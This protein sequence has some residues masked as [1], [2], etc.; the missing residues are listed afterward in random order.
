MRV[1]VKAHVTGALRCWAALL[2]AGMP[3][4]WITTSAPARQA[5][6]AKAADTKLTGDLRHVASH[7]ATLGSHEQ[8]CRPDVALAVRRAWLQRDTAGHAHA[9]H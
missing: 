5:R 2:H 6:V 1:A 8:R 9:V 3:L 7:V 4:H